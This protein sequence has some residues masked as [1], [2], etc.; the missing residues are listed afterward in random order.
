MKGV[1]LGLIQMSMADDAS[2]NLE[3][4]V[5]RIA[6]A[7]KKGAQIVCLPELFTTP[8]FPQEKSRGK[9]RYAEKVPG[10]TTSALSRAARENAVVVVGGSVFEKA[11]KRYYN[12][13]IAID[14][15][16]RLL[17][18]YRKMHIPHDPSFYEQ[19]YFLQGNLGFRVFR[20]QYAR[21]GTLICYDQWYPEAA[22]INALMKADIVFYPTA[23]GWVKGVEPTEGNWQ[24]AWENVQRGHAIAN[25]MIVAAVNRVGVEGDMAFWGGSFVCNAFGKT[26]ARGSVREEIV[27]ADCDLEHGKRVREGWRF[28]HNRRPE[29]Y[30]KL[31]EKK[32]EQ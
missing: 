24:E 15:K 9:D 14:D 13:S 8:Y 27:L 30:R 28:F 10:R 26:I 16:G 21:V 17:G 6:E 4:A 20:T 5:G 11:G 22:R 32:S 18:K 2:E 1:R 12:T 31:V 19:D 23:I 7:A 25:G 3:K 29:A